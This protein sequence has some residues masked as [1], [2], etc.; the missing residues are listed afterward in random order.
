MKMT[1]EEMLDHIK[2]F[3]NMEFKNDSSFEVTYNKLLSLLDKFKFNVVHGFPNG[4]Q[5]K[6]QLEEYDYILV[7]IGKQ[8]TILTK[9]KILG[10]LWIQEHKTP[11]NP[12][13]NRPWAI[14]EVDY[15]QP[16]MPMW[17]S[18]GWSTGD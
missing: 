9:G 16:N 7:T 1:L 8:D 3:D 15:S 2:K 18:R 6:I 12:Q 4:F 17:T 14:G 11:L 13:T 10:K 5:F